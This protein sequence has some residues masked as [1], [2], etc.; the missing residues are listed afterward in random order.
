MKAMRALEPLAPFIQGVGGFCFWEGGLMGKENA[1]GY[2]RVKIDVDTSHE[3]EIKRSLKNIQDDAD[4]ARRKLDALKQ[5]GVDENAKSYRET[6]AELEKYNKELDEYIRKHKEAGVADK[7]K[8]NTTNSGNFDSISD[9]LE[10]YETRLKMLRNKGYGPGDEHFD[11][12]YIAWKNA[13][14]AEKEYLAG[15]EKLTDKNISKETQKREDEARKLSEQAAEYEHIN[16]LRADAKVHDRNLIALLQEQE[17]IT[18]RMLELRQ[19]GV[20]EGYKEYDKLKVRLENV[21][22]RI[23][24]IRDGVSKA[25]DSAK[26]MTSGLQKS[27][28]SL[29]RMFKT[30]ASRMLL[31]F[32]VFTW[33][34]KAFTSMVT[35]IKDG[36]KNITEYSQEYNKTISANKSALAEL[37]NNFAAAFEPI[38]NTVIPYLTI[39]INSLNSAFEAFSRFIAYMSGKNTYTRAK[40]QMIDYKNAVD[41]TN[42]ALAKF[43]KLTVLD[44]N[45]SSGGEKTGADAFETVNLGEVPGSFKQFKNVYESYLR[46]TFAKIKEAIEWFG[47]KA[48]VLCEQ[49]FGDMAKSANGLWDSIVSLYETAKPYLSTAVDNAKRLFTVL[50]EALSGIW[51]SIGAPIFG[52]IIQILQDTIDYFSEHCGEMSDAFGAFVDEVE[53]SWNNYLKP[54]LG[55]IKTFLEE[56]LLPAFEAVFNDGILP[57]VGDVVEAIG[58]LISDS[59]LPEFDGICE[60]LTGVFTLDF[61]KAWNGIT[62]I[63]RA[64]INGIVTILELGVNAAIDGLNGFISMYNTVA[65]K[66]KV[67]PTISHLSNIKLSRVQDDWS[68]SD[69]GTEN[70]YTG[71]SRYV[72]SDTG[73]TYGK[74]RSGSNKEGISV[75]YGSRGTRYRS[76]EPM[77]WKNNNNLANTAKSGSSLGQG[78]N[79]SYTFVAQVDGKTLFKEVVNQDKLQRNR[80]GYSAFSD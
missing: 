41:S 76:S 31:N 54:A 45:Q 53:D 74:H 57:I 59:L 17:S 29:S 39:M 21:N 22:K 68:L 55:A 78:E 35:G 70:R 19:A 77:E 48:G 12:L 25:K 66:V 72:D 1:D 8:T 4:S 20:G 56:I 46:P 40:K 3:K 6:A 33:I 50:F 38:V 47:G 5:A 37:K 79:N 44:N 73:R 69:A 52:F 71:V 64:A 28:R 14:D 67:L 26:K 62:K 23:A 36:F 18:A 16:R 61:E 43:D 75:F 7:V 13:S 34:S 2:V 27:T 9:Q 60:F 63:V 80:T 42:Q 58:E 49:V 51:T 65:E 24:Q 10:D 11:E 15:L 30:M 32:L